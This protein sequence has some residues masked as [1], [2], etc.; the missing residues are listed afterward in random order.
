MDRRTGG[1]GIQKDTNL[2]CSPESDETRECNYEVVFFF[3]PITILS[4]YLRSLSHWPHKNGFANV[5]ISEG[6]TIGFFRLL[7]LNLDASFPSCH[8]L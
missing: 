6:S 5:D 2:H 1:T 4:N 3:T 7:W 8:R